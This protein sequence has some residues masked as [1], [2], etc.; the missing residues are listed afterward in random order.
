MANNRYPNLRILDEADLKVVDLSSFGNALIAKVPSSVA[1]A[2]NHQNLTDA[3]Q[4]QFQVDIHIEDTS[5]YGPDYFV[6]V[7]S[8]DAKIRILRK[9]F[10]VVCNYTIV[11]MPWTPHHGST[12]VPLQTLL[13]S[14]PINQHLH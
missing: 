13:N 7:H 10:V 9:G 3:I 12:T 4:Q 6:Q 11:F 5:K 8:S 1:D 14:H 2:I